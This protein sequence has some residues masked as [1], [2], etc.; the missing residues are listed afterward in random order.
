MMFLENV[1]VPVTQG[2]PPQAVLEKRYWWSTLQALLS[3]TALLQF[4]TFDLVGGMLTAMMLFLAFMMTTD[5]MAEMH[6]YA[7]A[8][9][10]L[11][12]LCLFFD[13]VPLLSSVGGRSEVSVE[14]VDRE[15][16]DNE[17]RITY[18]TIIKTMPFFDDKRGWMYNGASITLILSPMC[19]LL[20]AYLAG[21]A[22]IEMHSTA[23]DATREN[24][25]ANMEATRATENPRPRRLRVPQVPSTVLSQQGSEGERSPPESSASTLL[26]FSGQ[27]HR[28]SPD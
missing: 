8:Y 9:A 26:R 17:L 7:L 12:L 25:I 24:M 3:A 5:G 27:S 20:G 16:R 23:M 22:H 2:P 4:F 14:P 19:M 28:L 6:R 13:M 10:M 15:S 21:Q 1:S 18:T 11:S